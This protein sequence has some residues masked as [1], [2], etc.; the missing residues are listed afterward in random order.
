MSPSQ[1][2]LARAMDANLRA[3]HENLGFLSVAHGLMPSAAPSL[4]LADTHRAWDDLAG[5]LPELYGRLA[6]RRAMDAL[7]TLPADESALADG[8]L[9]RAGALLGILAHA[10]WWADREPPPALPEAVAAPWRTVSHRLGRPAPHLSYVDLVVYNWRLV[11][12]GRAHARQ[13]Q[14]MRLLIP[15]VGNEAEHVFYL[16]QAEILARCAPVV[17]AV[18]RAQGAVHA[19]DPDLVVDALGTVEACLDGVVR[20]ALPKI[21]PAR[22]SPTHVDPVLWAKTVAPFGVPF[23]PSAAGPSGTSSPV[24]H[25]LDAFFGRATYRSRL[26]REMTHLHAWHPPHWR[27]FVDAV[28]RTSVRG[29]VEARGQPALRA[30]YDG[31]LARYAGES[32]FLGRHRMKVYGYLE[33]AFK[34]G[35][36]VTIGGFSGPFR[37]R[38]WMDVDTEL[39]RAAAERH[40]G[41]A[42]DPSTGA[43][44]GAGLGA[45]DTV[46]PRSAVAVHNNDRVGYWIAVDG[47]VYDV[48]RFRRR[49]PGGID[50]LDAHA[51]TD[52]TAAFHRVGHHRDHRVRAL[53]ERHRIGTIDP[54]PH[55]TADDRE[56]YRSWT[57][58]TFLVSEMEN[59]LRIDHAVREPGSGPLD[60]RLRSEIHDR[61]RSTYLDAVTDEIADGLWRRTIAACRSTEDPAWMGDRVGR[62]RW[63]EH[64]AS[65]EAAGPLEARVRRHERVDTALLADV[66]QLLLVGAQLLERDGDRTELLT[67]LR[68]LP[69]IVARY[70]RSTAAALRTGRGMVRVRAG[71]PT[72][73]TP[74]PGSESPSR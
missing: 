11:D 47:A 64:V 71:T 72:G 51:G 17:D 1:R 22:W 42:P 29:Y 5:E 12:P 69:G 4:R 48:T 56:L 15:T 74:S 18:V 10:Y 6:V 30:A 21:S 25:V 60:L 16:T 28:R 32:G 67:I 36:T 2:V 44:A 54:V 58:A 49:H 14:N 66:K 68:R 33:L 40:A 27:D 52:A 3:G 37:A 57:N 31:A 63:S 50:I 53:A 38:T 65:V 46:V 55:L 26:G 19:D 8:D 34:V 62:I 73:W 23:Y 20:H 59:A 70:R 13:V 35:R 9:L 41:P 45:A 43:R 39:A 7:P 24:F 61:F